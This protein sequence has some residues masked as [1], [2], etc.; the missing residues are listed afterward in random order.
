MNYQQGAEKACDG[1]A[2][3]PEGQRG[4][5]E[6]LIQLEVKFFLPHQPGG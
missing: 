5:L 4:D 6:V 1:V 2:R 3:S